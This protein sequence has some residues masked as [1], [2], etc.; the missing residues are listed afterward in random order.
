MRQS[1]FS[2][3]RIFGI[4]VR[5][6]ATWLLA[7]FFITWSLASGY[8]RFVAPPR[9]GLATPLLL[10]AVSALLL[11]GSVLVHEFS[12]SLVARARGLR[13]RDITLFIFGGVSNISGEART[14]R[15]E[16]LIA[17]VG[18]LTSFALAGIFWLLAAWLGS[19]AGVGVLLG[20]ARGFRTLSPTGAVLSYLAVINLILGAF[21]LLPAFPLDGGRVF[22]SIVWGITHRYGRAT[23]LAT[24]VGQAFSW[25]LIGLGVVRLTLFGDLVGGVW[26]VFIG[27][28]LG[29]AAGATRR[30]QRLR[31]SL[32]GVRVE[33][34]MDPAPALVE[35]STSLQQLVIQYLL[36]TSQRRLVVVREGR[37]VGLIDTALVN[38]VPREQW[39]M[40]AV[41][42][43]MR[44]IPLMVPPDLEVAR[45]LERM[46]D[47]ERTSL[48]PVVADGR[49]VGVVE[50][51]QVLRYAQLHWELGVGSSELGRQV[52]ERSLAPNS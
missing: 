48:V 21:N 35:A 11:F 34:V 50:L 9:Q 1:S 31:E 28:F 16:F 2:I 3:G 32:R 51:R 14:A 24:G 15:D 6:H 23:A 18:P 49:V 25:L 45:L 12:H 38:R 5:V 47:D 46:G 29:Q 44:P 20:S 39:L 10:G 37:P 19:T 43:V 26:T 8:F 41:E 52:G 42:Q 4:E 7:F 33:Q 27:W 40:T 17:F 13:V 36:R 30:E 22:R